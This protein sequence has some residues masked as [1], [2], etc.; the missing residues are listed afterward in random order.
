MTEF[1][2]MPWLRALR[3]RNAEEEQ[4]LTTEQRFQKHHREAEPLVRDFLANHPNVKMVEPS[5]IAKVAEE[6]PPYGENGRPR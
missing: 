5:R 4:G 3:D 2:V 6:T 1:K